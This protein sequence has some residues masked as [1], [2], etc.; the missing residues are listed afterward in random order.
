MLNLTCPICGSNDYM[1]LNQYAK[2]GLPQY[3]C[4][5]AQCN[6]C[7]HYYTVIVRDICRDMLYQEGQ[8]ELVDT[9][10]TCFGKV[11]SLENKAVLNKLEWLMKRTKTSI[12]DI[13]CGKGVFLHHAAER[14]WKTAGIET[15]KKRAEFAQKQY[16]LSVNTDEYSEG[17]ITEAPFDVITLFHVLEHLAHPGDFLR[18]VVVDNLSANGILVI[19][20]PNFDSLQAR[21]AASNW[22][23]LDPPLHISH[24]SE[25]RL[26][27]ML[28]SIG[29]EI[30]LSEHFS[31]VN[32][33]LG[34]TQSI[35]SRFGYRKM[36][37]AE[38]KLKRTVG[39]MIVVAM[40]TP[41]AL[42]IEL[43]DVL[44][45]R[46]GIVRLYC[47]RARQSESRG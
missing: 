18:S 16:R 15:S 22:I 26:K 43:I 28:E 31:I 47:R 4:S 46:G 20:V 5:I 12:L 6:N 42:I 34:M 41:I 39:L 17:K 13:G 14:G 23:H 33:L 8:Y 2:I 32:G 1:T 35:M 37:I 24:F 9:R 44:L 25:K 10:Q 29:V 36:L 11:I 40:I 45:G 3:G 21:L 27:Q 30:V 7:G 19:E 38:L